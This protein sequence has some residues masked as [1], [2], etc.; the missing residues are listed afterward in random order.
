MTVNRSRPL[1]TA[2]L[3]TLAACGSVES[4]PPASVPSFAPPA[5]QDEVGVLVG[6]GDIADCARE[7]D[8][9]TAA[10]LDGIDGIVFTTGDNVYPAGS[11]STYAECYGP[12]WGRHL[13]RTRPSMGNHDAQGDDGAAYYAYFG[14]RAG[15]PGEG[16][17]SYE[18]GSW[19][20]VVLNSECGVAGGCEAGSAQHDWLVADL[21]ESQAECTLAYWHHARFSG[22]AHGDDPRTSAFWEA[23]HA[24]A[25][26]VVLV[27]H[28][29]GYQRFAPM[30]PSGDADPA[31]G[32]RQFVIGSGG[33][34]L[35][36]FETDAPSTEARDNT[37]FG[38]LRLDLRPGAYDWR[39]IPVEPDG[40][41]DVGSDTCH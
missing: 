7:T 5:S 14:D 32:I 10:L 16:W 28:D 25:A 36:A 41:T 38:V 29:H 18:L 40:F 33:K 4:A 39:F 37:S 8:E 9:A 2:L 27:G 26:D 24:A 6:S 19:H 17:Y 11:A 3:C 22:A 30:E 15:A 23:L 12:S 21:R 35:Y 20:I 13:D 1:L 31:G 34:E